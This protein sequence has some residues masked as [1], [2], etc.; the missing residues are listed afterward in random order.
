[1]KFMKLGT[2]PDSFQ[3]KGDNVRYATTELET[4]IIIIIGNVKFYL[5]KFPLLSKSGFLQRLIATSKNEEEK[6]NQIDEI[7]ISEI[8]GGSV[9]FEICVKFCYGITVT[10]NA[11]NVVAARC[12]A[13]F[14]EMNETF[15]KSNLVYKIDVFLNSTI[16]RSWKDS[17]IVLQTTKDLLSNYS[18]E[19]LKR[20]LDSIASTASIDTLKVKW[21]YS[22]NRKKKLENV[23][24]PEDAVPK[25]WWVEDLCDLHME[26][27]K[28][29]IEAIKAKGKVPNTVIGEALHAYAKRRIAG[30]SKGSMQIVDKS[31]TDTIIE[32][33][34]GEKRSVSSSFLTKLHRASIFLGYEETVKERL[35][36]RIS[37]QLE[38]TTVNDIL[39]Y[40]LDMVQSLVKEFM[41]RDPKTHSKASVAK[42]ID[43]Y[44]AE[45]SRDPNLPLQN[46]LSLAETLSSFPRQSH[47]GLYRAIDMFLKE[48]SGVSKSEKKRVCGLM[49]CRKLSAEACEHAVQNERLPMRVIVQV[50]FFEQLRANGSS[51]GYSTPELTTTTL[52]TEDDEWDHEKE[53]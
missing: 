33:I 42:L 28:Q 43:G 44:L 16:F 45:K 29:A 40:D 1:M 47:D 4:E 31:L 21:S 15:E 22:Y 5:H 32:L 39:M 53:F 25:D 7:D 14:L 2:K 24:K 26:L 51:T 19:L 49:D 36:K 3:S 27:Y 48:H 20:C 18:E 12:A 8:P 6:K 35:K 17:I 52:N 38:E 13:E 50:L 37:E 11:Y 34:P 41:N 9:A 46:F 10:L 23:K 30:F